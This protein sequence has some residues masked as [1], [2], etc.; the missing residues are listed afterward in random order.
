MHSKALFQFV[1]SAEI[2]QNFANNFLNN[3]KNITPNCKI[4]L[5]NKNEYRKSADVSM[6]FQKANANNV[7][8]IIKA[9]N[10]APGLDCIRAIDIKKISHNIASIIAKLININIEKNTYPSEL[11]TGIIRPIFKGAVNW[12]TITIHPSLFSPLLTKSWK[13][14]YVTKFINFMLIITYSPKT[15]TDFNLGTQPSF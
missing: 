15:S 11:K 3:V 1:K 4:P 2:V 5:L 12:T 13:N 7:L 10:K 6:N 14:L 8:E 9:M